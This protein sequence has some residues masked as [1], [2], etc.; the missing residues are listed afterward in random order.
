VERGASR[1]DPDGA[2][3][4]GE[5]VDEV[6]GPLERCAARSC[7]SSTR[8]APSSTRAD[9]R[10]TRAIRSTSRRPPASSAGTGCG[11][12]ARQPRGV[13]PAAERRR[14]EACGSDRCT[15]NAARA[16]LS[17]RIL[18]SCSHRPTSVDESGAPC[19]PNLAAH[20][21]N[22]LGPLT[23]RPARRT[24][25]IGVADPVHLNYSARRS[26]GSAGAP[27]R[28]S[29]RLGL[30]EIGVMHRATS[31]SSVATPSV[32][33]GSIRPSSTFAPHAR[34]SPAAPRRER[35][36]LR[37][38]LGGERSPRATSSR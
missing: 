5:T 6:V 28:S 17:G 3:T 20:I 38:I 14:L 19:A 29:T 23:N 24:R 34:I 1:R 10:P 15:P 30:D 27:A 25:S 31:I 32:A 26:N 13:E 4:K 37:A 11:R 18:R 9:R 35:R 2:P 12:Q 21:F 36:A 33:G 7:A 8:W 22:L 16:G